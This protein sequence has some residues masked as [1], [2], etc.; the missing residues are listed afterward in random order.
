VDHHRHV[1]F[2]HRLAQRLRREA[3][4]RPG[5]LEPGRLI[6]WK[7]VLTLKEGGQPTTWDEL[8]RLL[9]L[10]RSNALRTQLDLDGPGGRLDYRWVEDLM[11]GAHQTNAIP[12]GEIPAFVPELLPYGGIRNCRGG[13]RHIDKPGFPGDNKRYGGGGIFGGY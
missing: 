5:P 12:A 1:F 11:L 13:G 2:P 4:F 8:I 9:P 10:S 6:D 3:Q 7:Y